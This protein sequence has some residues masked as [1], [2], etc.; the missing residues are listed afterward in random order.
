MFLFRVF[1][2]CLR[3]HCSLRTSEKRSEAEGEME[4]QQYMELFRLP[5]RK[6]FQVT[7]ALDTFTLETREAIG[8]TVQVWSGRPEAHPSADLRCPGHEPGRRIQRYLEAPQTI[9]IYLLRHSDFGMGAWG[10]LRPQ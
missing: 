9:F 5:E 3:V 4:P 10:L 1:G 6:A 7:G 2:Q 8:H